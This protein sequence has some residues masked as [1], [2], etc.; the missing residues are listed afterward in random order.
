MPLRAL[1]L[2]LCALAAS[3]PLP[4]GWVV[5]PGQNAVSHCPS[6][7]TS[8]GPFRCLGL[9]PGPT[10]AP[11]F[12]AC[13]ADSDCSQ[14]TWASDDGRCFTRTDGAW[15]LV[16]GATVAACNNATVVGCEPPPPSNNTVLTAEVASAPS[17]VQLHA[18]A[19]AVTLDGWNG[20][21]FP[22][23]GTGSYLALD[24]DSPRL[25]ALASALAPGLLRLG[26]S[27]EDSIQFDPTG[28]ACVAGSGGSGPAP[29][30]YFCSQVRPYT[31]G[32]LTGA[33]WEALLA[34]AARTGLQLILG[35]NGCY[36]RMGPGSPMD[37]SNVAALLQATAAS[38]HR[39]ALHGLELSNEV[40]GTSITPSAWGA[41]M[42][43]LR[44]L[45]NS[46]LGGPLPVLA[47]PDDASPLHLAQAL[48]STQPGTLQA[49]TYHHYPGCEANTSAYFALD[50]SCLS[51]IDAWG[52]QFSAAAGAPAGVATWAGE[53][54][55]HGGGGVTGL[56][57]S[58]TSSLYYAWQ[59]GALPLVG[60]QLSARQALVG[61]DYELL[62]RETLAPNP[63][64]WV[65]WLFKALVGG[66]AHAH[67]VNMSTPVSHSGVR[68][69]AF[70]A[71]AG[72]GRSLLAL[73]LNTVGARI[74]VEVGGGGSGEWGGGRVEYHLQGTLGLAGGGVTCN[75]VALE[76]GAAG[77]L[78]DWRA[79][80]V[81]AAAGSLL[82]LA[83]SSIVFAT[84]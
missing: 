46:T 12:A 44:E 80:G 71:G 8:T 48:N 34:F 31:Y 78:P 66:G 77:Q 75:G 25:L 32:C 18:L 30:G 79:L 57:D 70:S 14:A 26:G 73:S 20:T 41:D 56:T 5:Y 7:C 52:A 38:P 19:P 49:L 4:S 28:T 3:Q 21:L 24:L 51:I 84:L 68:V 74:G 67:A 6:T 69:Y 50:P 27:P 13:L 64:Y 2:L 76:V 17:G 82:Q 1:P 43:T 59:L 36:Q 22:R 54:A 61:G 65:L 29:G 62:S 23:W 72:G 16:G 37:F 55:A 11:C 10:A 63:D 60:V 47:G 42:D 81:P 53:T 40:F 33:R 39:A 35:V 45:V 58:F 83:P 9:F 15:E